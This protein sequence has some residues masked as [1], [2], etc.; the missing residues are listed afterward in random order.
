MPTSLGR[1][2]W[3]CAV[4]AALSHCA[5][6]S[7]AELTDKRLYEAPR[8]AAP[9]VID[10]RLEDA[11]WRQAPATGQFW[12]L[13]ALAE[14]EPT[15]FQACYDE[16]NLYLA[17]T[18]GEQRPQS[19]R[20]EVRADDLSAL[21]GDDAVEIFLRPDPAAGDYYQFAAN[22]L[23]TRY[24]GKAFDWTWNGRWQAAAAVG[25]DAWTL[26]CAIAFEPLGRYGVAG[27]TW[28][29]QVCRDREAGETTEWSAWSP[30]PGGFHQPQHFGQ[31]IFGGEASHGDRAA[32]IE[33]ARAAQTSLALQ[34][35]L[36]RDL[37]TVRGHDFS[38]LEL[39]GRT[40]VQ[41]R[42]A[43]AEKALQ[44]LREL[45]AGE[46]L[47]DPQAWQQVNAALQ[48]A[49]AD[50]DETAWSVRFDKLLAD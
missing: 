21:M 34:E 39:A 13:K 8:A 16:H 42:V 2:N 44:A 15:S 26:E 3:L 1:L 43:R 49:A 47:L 7:P 37:Q 46:A 19:L 11:C 45:L 40:A 30:T 32:L 23:G 31:V 41:A 10:G 38:G 5:F 27:A 14:I 33:C 29:L 9:P 20:A 6:A 48:A 12:P 25:K 35:R 17:V 18:C 28:G 4:L 50:L 24:D 22:C 36:T